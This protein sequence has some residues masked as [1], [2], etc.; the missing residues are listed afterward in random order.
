[1]TLKIP[2][3]VKQRKATVAERRK[4]GLPKGSTITIEHVD[5]HDPNLAPEHRDNFITGVRAEAARLD[6]FTAMLYRHRDDPEYGVDNIADLAEQT[7]TLC[8]HLLAC[9][10]L[11]GVILVDDYPHLAR[12]LQNFSAANYARLT[13]TERAQ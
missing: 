7:K 6:E 2:N 13:A 3:Q 10:E 11:F 9:K 4:F 1:M 12:L 5:L 8:G